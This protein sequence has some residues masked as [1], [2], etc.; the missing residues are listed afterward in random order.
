MQ[1]APN[2]GDPFELTGMYRVAEAKLAE[3][4]GAELKE[5]ARTGILA[6]I[7]AHLLSLENFQRLLGRRAALTELAFAEQPAKL[8]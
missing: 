6:R 3:L 7:F 8:N 2:G 4:D 5:F 1:A